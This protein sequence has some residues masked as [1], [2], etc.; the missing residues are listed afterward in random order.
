MILRKRR[1]AMR[2][3]EAAGLDIRAESTTEVIAMLVLGAKQHAE[4]IRS[5]PPSSFKVTDGMLVAMAGRIMAE[6]RTAIE[7]LAEVVGGVDRAMPILH[8]LQEAAEDALVAA[9]PSA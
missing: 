7:R 9:R 5:S 3:T 2:L 6:N 4:M 8:R 1:E